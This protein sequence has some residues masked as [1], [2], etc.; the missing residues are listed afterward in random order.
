M[1]INSGDLCSV[2][3]QG[4]VPDE[5]LAQRRVLSFAP[6]RDRDIEPL[7]PLDRIRRDDFRSVLGIDRFAHLLELGGKLLCL[8]RPDKLTDDDLT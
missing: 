8:S 5:V 2:D 4:D 3:V 1:E 7:T 6:D